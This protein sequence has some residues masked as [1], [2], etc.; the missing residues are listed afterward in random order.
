ML[1]IDQVPNTGME[2]IGK[3]Q[4]LLFILIDTRQ[5]VS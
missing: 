1:A 4:L 3:V 5:L 2:H